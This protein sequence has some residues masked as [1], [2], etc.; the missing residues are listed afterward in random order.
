MR[1]LQMI[2][3]L[4]LYHKLVPTRKGEMQLTAVSCHTQM[5][6]LKVCYQP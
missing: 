5:H 1:F 3:I 2:L 4:D 6:E